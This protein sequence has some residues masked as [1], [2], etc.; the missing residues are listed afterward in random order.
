MALA[1]RSLGDRCSSMSYSVLDLAKLALGV[2]TD[3]LPKV[4]GWEPVRPY[5][6]PE[7][8]GFYAGLYRQDKLY[9]LAYRGTDDWQ[10]DLVDD[11]TILLG[12]IS[13]Q[14]GQARNAL[15]ESR[16]IL[17]NDLTRKICLTGHPLGGGL[18]ALIAAQADL[19]CVTFNAP[20]TQ[21]SLKAHYIKHVSGG[22][23]FAP[24]I[25]IT[26]PH[27]VNDGRILNI[28]ARFDLVSV[29]TGPSVG[30]TDS[31]NVQ[32]EGASGEPVKGPVQAGVDGLV[33]SFKPTTSLVSAPGFYKGVIDYT[34]C[35]HSMERMLKEVQGFD[36]YRRDLGW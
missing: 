22:P 27:E 30:V 5:G 2:Y 9:V 17:A 35:Q 20:G 31:V 6:S 11:G 1:T 12:W 33:Q 32:C 21:R 19:P 25:Q 16:A 13:K 8:H 7:K 3:P 4:D 24:M 26:T 34:L 10:V 36:K 15:R 18:A 14:M 28:R 23:F 29:G